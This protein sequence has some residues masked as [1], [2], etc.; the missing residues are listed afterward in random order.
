ML[1]KRE[2][3]LLPR[4][5][6][7]LIGLGSF[8]FISYGFA[9]W[10]T[11]IRSDVGSIVFDWEQ[12]IPL[13]GWT[14]VPYWSIDLLYGL[15]ILLA[16]NKREL[17]TLGHRLLTAQ[18]ICVGC[19][20]LFPLR[21]TFDRPEL[22]G[23]FG[24]MFDI[25]MG[26]DKP[27][28]QAPS[29]HIS[30][31]VVLW[32]FYANHLTKV[33]RWLLHG[34]FFLIGVS[35]LTTWQHHFFDVPTGALVGCLCIWLWPENGVSPLRVS[36]YSKQWNGGVFYL[37]CSFVVASIAI[38]LGGAW[39][40]LA[41]LAISLLLVSLNYSFLGAT[42]FQKQPNGKFCLPVMLLYLPYL[43]VAWLN[44]RLWT[45]NNN[46]ADVVINKVYLGRI[47]NQATLINYQFNSIVD[48]CAELPLVNYQ[49]NYCLIPVLDL[50]VP[51]IDI[52]KQAVLVI[53]Q[54]QQ[55]GSVLVCCAL[56]Y[57]RSAMAIIA[58]LLWSKQA[59][60]VN[61]AIDIVKKVRSD[62]VINA[63]QKEILE[64]WLVAINNG[65]VC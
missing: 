45:R 47:P 23:F 31:L 28:N 10:V 34:W 60:S 63:G 13:W 25:L 30:L 58:W 22:D 21:F 16:T 38:Y 20:L 18:L 40:W 52:C 32:V 54:Y 57:S 48:F 5:W 35:V 50:T 36:Q 29:L 26:F 37:C 55:Q 61:N 24:V 51:S 65:T 6:L 53:E 12:S 64:K 14:I 33:W 15:A 41:W 4:A 27:F 56:G 49:G 1:F 9:N 46:A 62:I 39:L 7:W 11:S 8:F 59:S 44:S 3:G 19:F 43:I 2:Q 42:G 17:D